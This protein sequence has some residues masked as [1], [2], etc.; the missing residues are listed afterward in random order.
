MYICDKAAELP[1]LHYSVEPKWAADHCTECEEKKSMIGK[2]RCDICAK[3]NEE[4][5]LRLWT[6]V[7]MVSV[8]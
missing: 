3:W 8:W 4:R 5:L 7:C 1:P 2:A 6:L